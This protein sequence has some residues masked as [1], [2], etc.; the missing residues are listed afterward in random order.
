ML[1]NPVQFFFWTVGIFPIL[2]DEERLKLL[3]IHHVIQRL[4]FLNQKISS[5]EQKCIIVNIVNLRLLLLVICLLL[6]KL[7]VILAYMNEGAIILE[8]IN[9][10]TVTDNVELSWIS[11]DSR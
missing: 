4:Q 2:S 6:V 5:I 3:E 9:M 11:R 8:A 7:K 1:V 10:Y